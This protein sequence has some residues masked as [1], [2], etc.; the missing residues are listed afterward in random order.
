MG[1]DLSDVILKLHKASKTLFKWFNINQMKVNPNKCHFTC[2][3]IVKTSIILENVQIR[4]SSYDK[5]LGVFFNGKLTFQSIIDNICKK[6]ITKIK[7][8]TRTKP[9]IDSNFKK[10]KHV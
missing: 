4:N 7:C 8:Y 5:I 2:S 3:F 10:Y 1:D 6:S 9:Y